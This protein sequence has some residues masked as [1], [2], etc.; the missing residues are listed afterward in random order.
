MAISVNLLSKYMARST[1][2]RPLH[3]LAT[4]A[5]M[6]RRAKT[7]PPAFPR[8][9]RPA[10]VGEREHERVGMLAG[11]VADDATPSALTAPRDERPRR[12]ERDRLGPDQGRRVSPAR[13]EPWTLCAPYQASCFGLA[14][15][16]GKMRRNQASV[17]SIERTASAR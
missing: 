3:P 7:I 13:R 12:V 10:G 15:S 9:A 2:S 5:Y 16:T 11:R 8:A 6:T 4:G 17:A 1:S 14:A